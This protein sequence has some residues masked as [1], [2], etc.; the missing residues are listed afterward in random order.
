MMISGDVTLRSEEDW[1]AAREQ[2]VLDPKKINLNAGTLS[3][4]PRPVLQRVSQLRE[5]MSL[6]PSDFCWRQ[7]PV[8]IEPARAALA[9][10]LNVPTHELLLLENPTIAANTVIDSLELPPGTQVITTDHEYGAI[11]MALDRRARRD[12]LEVVTI[13]LPYNTESPDEIVAL[14]AAAIN[15]RTSAILFSHIT[16][17]MGLCLPAG[18][19]CDLARERGVMSAIDGSHA[20][21]AI[22]LDLQKIAA[23]VYVGSCHKWMMAPTGA[24]FMHVRDEHKFEVM[25]LITSW[26]L[27]YDPK[28]KDADSGWGGTYW[29]RAFEFHGTA[30]RCAQMV[31]PDVLAF[32]DSL[33]GEAAIR[34]RMRQLS[35]YVRATLGNIGLK[36]ATP[37]YQSGPNL[38]AFEFDGV[39]PI[40]WRNW[41][42]ETHGI[43]CPITPGGGRHFLRVSTAWFNNTTEVDALARA[44][45]D[46]KISAAR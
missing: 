22:E 2:L 11:R 19:L 36:V 17:S 40:L 25:P 12:G 43:E 14:F 18:P 10:F 9:K 5:Q 24:A 30:D 33:G 7:L 23:D 46:W 31:L 28:Q 27:A 41:L 35:D 39:D 1:A 16:A 38:T 13:K 21:G 34:H 8:L 29:Q 20:P 26:G 15:D 3:P 42:W 6:N 45:G 44:I 4:T 32:R 37:L